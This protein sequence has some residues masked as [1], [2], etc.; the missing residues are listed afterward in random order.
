ME[1]QW[2]VI[3]KLAE[4]TDADL[5]DWKPAAS[6]TGFKRL[7]GAARR[8]A[9]GAN[10]IIDAILLDLD[11][12]P[13]QVVPPLIPRTGAKRSSRPEN[14]AAFR[15]AATQRVMLARRKVVG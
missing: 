9:P 13:F 5:V 12:V 7:F 1:R 11:D 14:L 6:N 8:K 10:K 3:Q 4:R 2:K 15:R